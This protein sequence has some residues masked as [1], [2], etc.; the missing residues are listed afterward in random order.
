MEKTLKL[1]RVMKKFMENARFAQSL[2][3]DWKIHIEVSYE[4][5]LP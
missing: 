4:K 3:G 1:S 5:K 2:H